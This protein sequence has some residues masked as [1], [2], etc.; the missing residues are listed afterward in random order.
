MNNIKNFDRLIKAIDTAQHIAVISHMNLDGDTMGSA[1]ALYSALKKYGKSP[2]LFCNDTVV[3][4]KLQYIDGHDLYNTDS[5]NRYDLVISVDSAD[6]ERLAAAKVEF[7]KGIV[8]ANV[9][10]HITNTRYAEINVVYDCAATCQIIY[11]IVDALGV[12]DDKI[13]HALY[14]GL[15][16]DSGAFTYS[17]V[18][19]ETMLVASE[20]LKY[21]V[22]PTE[23]CDKLFREITLREFRLKHRVLNKVRFYHGNRIGIVV[24]EKDD[25]IAT[26]TDY[27]N[28]EGI[29]NCIRDIDSVDVAVSIAEVGNESYKISFR[30]SESVDCSRIAMHFGGGGHIRAS[31]CKLN[32]LLE[33]VVERIVKAS[34]DEIC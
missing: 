17:S 2:Y 20:L 3:P 4:R 26:D 10:H 11:Y 6:Y 31:G 9:D 23:I 16:T 5:R 27:S 13:A 12:L 8:K 14:C 32:G 29:V 24:F 22:H 15:T 18:N 30:S 19:S 25:F 33:E 21:K 7:D 1:I 28:T 34:I